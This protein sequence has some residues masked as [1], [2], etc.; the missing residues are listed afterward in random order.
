MKLVLEQGMSA[1]Q[2]AKDLGLT[3]PVLSRW[4]TKARAAAQPGA[5][6]DHERAELTRLRQENNILRKERAILKKA[7]LDSRRQRT[8]AG[9]VI[10]E[11][12]N[13][14]TNWLH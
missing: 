10:L 1:T 7:A 13:G 9:G 8:T 2:A 5:L 6:S 12:R 11:G 14:C 3:Q 4:V